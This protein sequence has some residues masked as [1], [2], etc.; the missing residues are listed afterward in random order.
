MPFVN[1]QKEFQTE[2]NKKIGLLINNVIPLS[3]SLT[4]DFTIKIGEEIAE[5]C[6]DYYYFYTDMLRDMYD[7]PDEYYLNAGMYEY[8]LNGRKYYA[9]RRSEGDNSVK[10]CPTDLQ[11]SFFLFLINIGLHG[12]LLDNSLS[13]KSSFFNKLVN[14]SV[15]NKAKDYLIKK[16]LERVYMLERVGLCIQYIG[17]WVHITNNKYPKMFPVLCALAKNTTEESFLICP[18]KSITGDF[19][20]DYTCS[21]RI[22]SEEEKGIINEI[23]EH[24]NKQHKIKAEYGFGS[25]SWNRKG[26]SLISL[27]YKEPAPFQSPIFT[28]S[29]MGIYSWNDPSY[30]LSAIENVSEELKKYFVSHLKYCQACSPNGPCHNNFYTIFG[31][32][33]RL[34]GGVCFIIDKNIQK[35]NLS[36][37]KQIIDIR[38]KIAKEGTDNIHI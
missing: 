4:D 10:K 26:K 2:V 24:I 33:K 6:K 19:K 34:C 25:I 31:K 18:L 14:Q 5:S 32:T 7:N 27:G 9:V 15:K 35:N 17:D 16:P 1:K 21:T 37:I 38:L 13:I 11:R 36:Y 22:M 3:E 28:I 12:E 30:Y 8:V 20:P 23:I 29:I